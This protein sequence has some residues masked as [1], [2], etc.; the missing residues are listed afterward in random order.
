MLQIE[1]ITVGKIKFAWIR[2]GINHYLKLISKFA[3]VKLTAVKEAD[4]SAMTVPQILAVEDERIRRVLAPRG[5]V[6]L[7]DV[8]GK[9]YESEKFSGL[10]SHAKL[11][12]SSM[13]LIIGGAYGLSE[14]LKTDHPHHLS[15]SQMTFPHELT[16]VILLEQLYRAC[17][18][19]AGS[20]Y[21]K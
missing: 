1:I 2:E 21:H 16:V 6:I 10:M 8:S 3:D 12:N 4:N 9:C 20:K 14:S 19:E 5:L 18:I 11:S 13:Q 15:L 17:A 7:L